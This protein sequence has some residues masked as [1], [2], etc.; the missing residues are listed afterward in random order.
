M[1]DKQSDGGFTERVPEPTTYTFK[2][3]T[4]LDFEQTV[5]RTIYAIKKE[6]A[7]EFEVDARDRIEINEITFSPS[8]EES[9]F[10]NG[11]AEVRVTIRRLTHKGGFDELEEK[12][13]T[14]L[15]HLVGEQ[16]D[17]TCIDT[18]P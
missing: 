9:D 13:E 5:Q 7:S 8:R 11:N 3:T 4:S 16:S 6:L 18:L 1:T 17:A 12:V 15:T 14:A 2:A 10:S